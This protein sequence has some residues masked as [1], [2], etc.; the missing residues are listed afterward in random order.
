MSEHKN[1]ARAHTHRAPMLMGKRFRGGGMTIVELLLAMSITSIVALAASG[2][3]SAVSYGQSERTDLRSLVVRQQLVSHRL[4]AAIRASR[5]VLDA[6]A[7]MLA[8]WTSDTNNDGV[9]QVNEVRWIVLA[10]DEQTITSHVVSF[11]V[12]WTDEQLE[13]TN[14]DY[15]TGQ[16]FN[17]Q[18]SGLGNYVTSQAW[19]DHVSGWQITPGA[20]AVANSRLVSFRVTFNLENRPA[21]TIIG[22]SALR[23]Q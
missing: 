6:N 23:S 8:L 9:A 2:M 18:T 10:S 7:N 20:A 22:A 21:Q 14:R 16:T 13:Q 1:V 15:V 12:A 17:A 19:A 4:S 3:L 5:S 11:P